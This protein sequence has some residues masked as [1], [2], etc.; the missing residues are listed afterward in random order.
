MGAMNT[1]SMRG[2]RFS[3]ALLRLGAALA[4]G[5]GAHSACA[6]PGQLDSSFGTGGTTTIT[7]ATGKLTA[8]NSIVVAGSKVIVGG[9]V[10][11]AGTVS[12]AYT[13]YNLS[14]VAVS[15][16]RIHTKTF[17]DIAAAPGT[18]VIA[19]T[20]TPPWNFTE[21]SLMP[22]FAL[23]PVSGKI[24]A[25]GTCS[26]STG[27]RRPC[28]VRFNTDGTSDSS[29]NGNTG[30]W[31]SSTNPDG[32]TTLAA[33]QF[34]PDGRLLMAATCVTKEG[35]VM[36][37]VF[38]RRMCVYRLN[39]DGTEDSTTFASP[40]PARLDSGSGRATADVAVGIVQRS[41][42]FIGI[43]GRCLLANANPSAQKRWGACINVIDPTQS[44][45]SFNV[46][47]TEIVFA[48]PFGYTYPTAVARLADNSTLV[49]GGC[50]TG[51]P[52]TATANSSILRGCTA[53]LS[54]TGNAPFFTIAQ[55]FTYS[56]AD[57]D[58][59]DG[60]ALTAADEHRMYR[61]VFA[62]ASGKV[63]A[64]R[65][66]PG[67]SN[68]CCLYEAV[69]IT[70]NGVDEVSP[71]WVKTQIPA[72][73]AVANTGVPGLAV[74]NL[75]RSYSGN[76]ATISGVQE[77]RL[78]RF[79]GDPITCNFNLDGSTNATP[80]AG[81]DGVIALRY[82][83]GFKDPN[84]TQG[85]IGAGASRT[86]YAAINSFITTTCSG[87]TPTSCNLDIDGDGRKLATTDGV[88]LI[89]AMLGIPIVTNAVG[90]GA[91][92]NTWALIRPFL[93]NNCGMT[94]LPP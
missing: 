85:A 22:Q 40:Q 12:F 3:R 29:F 92:R 30:F 14:G 86:D 6:L 8:G 91:A 63:I 93:V 48:A 4:L 94:G 44:V 26:F 16:A 70:S 11:A 68:S 13:E 17:A 84:F 56:A 36:T 52:A 69:R 37:P 5:H 23:D 65:A 47:K 76:H 32:E 34:Q 24:V 45:G 50:T 64:V 49:A 71:N 77:I 53:K 82:L 2:V 1:I 25:A 39:P 15:T 66:K 41:D 55:D 10:G 27:A 19:S 88:L 90:A 28:A 54:W 67:A 79:E 62:Q 57:A 59:F 21:E 80:D 81:T 9:R 7:P 43:V 46:Y 58:T 73:T 31:E 20:T 74:D 87:T 75:G 42:T 61:S 38:A 60:V 51:V 83:A 18:N 78:S 35:P 72:I 89:R 33:I